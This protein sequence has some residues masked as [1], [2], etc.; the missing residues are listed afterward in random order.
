VASL[1]KGSRPEVG[2]PV[3][4]EETLAALKALSGV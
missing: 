1:L 3:R 4:F 2:A